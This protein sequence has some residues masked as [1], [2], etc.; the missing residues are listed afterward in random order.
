MNWI[1]KEDSLIRKVLK[2]DWEIFNSIPCTYHKVRPPLEIV[3]STSNHPTKR[4][5]FCFRVNF[6]VQKVYQLFF[7]KQCQEWVWH[8]W[9]NGC[10]RAHDSVWEP[11]RM[12]T[13]Q[14]GSV[15]TQFL[16]S[17][18]LRGYS[19][20]CLYYH[21]KLVIDYI[22]AYLELPCK[23]GKDKS[24]SDWYYPFT[25]WSLV[26]LEL[27]LLIA[28][29]SFRHQTLNEERRFVKRQHFLSSWILVVHKMCKIHQHWNVDDH[30]EKKSGWGKN[31]SGYL[32]FNRKNTVAELN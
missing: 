14:R 9:I 25:N 21:S 1:G 11:P 8:K 13:T 17:Y 18:K 4:K 16:K 19:L 12:S 6:T 15:W 22:N 31:P 30:N 26:N 20:E 2:S 24:W 27:F 5:V 29:H 7:T 10:K 23:G 32:E 3:L 28:H